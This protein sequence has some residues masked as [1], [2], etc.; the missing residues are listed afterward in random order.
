MHTISKLLSLVILAAMPTFSQAQQLKHVRPEKVGMDSQQL[1]KADSIIEN[2]IKQGD[3]PGAVLAVV[4]HSKMA[5]LKAYGNRQVWPEVRPMT[6][7]TIFDMASCSKAMSTAISALILCEEGKFRMLD[8]VNRYIPGFEN[9]KD[10]SGETTTIR[11]HHLMT[12]TSGLPAYYSPDPQATPNPDA[13]IEHI[14][15]MKRG[16]EPGK[17]FRYSCLN[18]IT[19]QH[20]IETISRMSLRDFSRQ[21]IFAPLGMNHTDYIP[22]APDANGVW[23]NTDLPCWAA[24]MPKGEDWRSIV[25]PTTK[26]GPDSVLCGMVHD[27]L[28]RIMNGGISGNAGLFSSAE[29]IAILCAMLQNEGT[30]NG[31]RIMSKQTAR[32]LRTVPRFAEAFG[33]TYGWDCYSDYASCNGDIF[34][35]QT[36][37]HT[38]FTGTG[39]V[40]DPEMDCSVI[41]LTNSVH[42][43]EG[44]STVR[45]RSVVSNAVAASITD[46]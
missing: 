1:L 27:P 3:I 36:Y 26:Q 7:N 28:A 12:H 20:I 22:C 17:G 14:S 19:L 6:T 21:H 10:A 24:L 16:F 9:W 11:I 37:C 44:G 2:A 5:Y 35:K 15:H 29:D 8:A 40:I 30:W 4:R 42:P 46:R 18:F 32:M 41:L 31:K 43:D 23:H 33:R 38:G 25:A 34:S 13:C 45:L 39:I